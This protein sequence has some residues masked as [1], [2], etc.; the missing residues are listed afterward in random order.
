MRYVHHPGHYVLVELPRRPL[1]E[2]WGLPGRPWALLDSLG[3]GIPKG[4][5]ETALARE[6]S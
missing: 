6:R 1:G 3:R 2:V 4:G 5:R